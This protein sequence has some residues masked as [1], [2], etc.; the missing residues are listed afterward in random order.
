[1]I[2]D[3]KHD[4]APR[5]RILFVYWGRRGGVNPMTLALARAA[6]R[7][8][9]VEPFLSVSSASELY[10]DFQATGIPLMAVDTFGR[11]VR[12]LWRLPLGP[13]Q[14]S[15]LGRFVAAHGIKAVITLMPHVWTPFLAPVVRQAAARYVVVMHD[16]EPHPG[17]PSA[18]VNA[19]L[20]RDARRADLVFTLSRHVAVRLAARGVVPPDRIRVLFAPTLGDPAPPRSARPDGPLRLLFFGRILPYKGLGLLLDALDLLARRGVAVRLGVVGNGDLGPHRARLAALDAEIDNRWVPEAEVAA[21]LDRFDAVALPYTEASQSGVVGAAMAAGLPVLVTPV[22]GL[23]EQVT[24]GETGLV[25]AA[26]TPSAMAD[27]LARLATDPAL[28]RRLGAGAAALAAHRSP[29]AM[30]TAMVEALGMAMPDS[31][32]GAPTGA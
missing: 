32:G 27:A 13:V 19:W 17:D 6:E 1:M 8:P 29:A 20:E 31:T 10:D 21:V 11:G 4:A 18:V 26:V 23:V 16:G 28:V 15:R 12:D 24:D 2:D 14:A 7:A 9:A 5:A 3:P 25:A 22:G 30:L